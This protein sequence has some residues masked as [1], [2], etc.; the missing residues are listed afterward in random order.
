MAHYLKEEFGEDSV[1]TI[2][3]WHVSD[4]MIKNSQFAAAEAS[5]IFVYSRDVPWSNLHPENFDG[6]ILMHER[7]SPGHKLSYIFSKNIINA[8]IER[9]QL[10]A[11]YLPGYLAEGY[12]GKAEES[13]K[14]L[15]G[16]NF[17]N[18]NDWKI[19]NNKNNFDGFSRL[20][21]KEFENDIINDYYGNPTDA[22]LKLKLLELGFGTGIMRPDLIP[23]AKWEGIW[24]AVLPQIKYL[25]SVGLVWAGTQE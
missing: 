13:L 15:T 14:L 1:L 19:W 16:Q 4:Q 6:Y 8:D 18:L 17:N 3:Q 21:S 9:M 24:K 22:K 11:K 10:I 23:R 25:N 12:Y 2:N 5:N 7:F 20:D